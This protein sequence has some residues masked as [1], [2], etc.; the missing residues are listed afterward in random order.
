MEYRGLGVNGAY[1]CI[2]IGEFMD[3]KSKEKQLNRMLTS[4]HDNCPDC[5]AMGGLCPTHSDNGDALTDSDVPSIPRGT[6]G[7]ASQEAKGLAKYAYGGNVELEESMKRN[8]RSLSDL[9]LQRAASKIVPDQKYADGGMVRRND[10]MSTHE[11][12]EDMQ[13]EMV[14]ED[15]MDFKNREDVLDPDHDAGAVDEKEDES[16]SGMA[17]K[18]RKR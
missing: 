7:G 10:I 11:L 8:P 3:I 6:E 12:E 18:R 15:A 5:Y 13:P 14:S 2:Y 9:A 4:A 17:L 1:P 16:L